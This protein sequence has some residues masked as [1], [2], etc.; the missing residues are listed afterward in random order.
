MLTLSSKCSGKGRRM[1]LKS[2]LLVSYHFHFRLDCC[3]Y[4]RFV[5]FIVTP[6]FVLYSLLIVSFVSFITLSFFLFLFIIL[7]L[8]RCFLTDVWWVL[9]CSF[10]FILLLYVVCSSEM[11]LSSFLCRRMGKLHACIK[12]SRFP[13]FLANTAACFLLSII[14]NT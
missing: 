8:S 13:N 12:F 9:F 11:S 1:G 7:Y 6:S 14:F 10:N 4:V 5:R 2:T 3:F